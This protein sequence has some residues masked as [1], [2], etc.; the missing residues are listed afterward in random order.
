MRRLT[1]GKIT[2][3]IIIFSLL[4]VSLLDAKPM[5]LQ[6]DNTS[7]PV[8]IDFP[9]APQTSS[10]ATP[11]LVNSMTYYFSA[12]DK[13]ASIAYAVT[14]VSIPEK[15][16]SIPNDTAQIMIS[17]SLDTQIRIVDAA[18]GTKGKVIESGTA[19]ITGYPSKFL[20]VVRE[21]AP[22][23]FGYYRAVFVDRLLVTVWASG[24]DTPDNRSHA[25]AFAQSLRIKH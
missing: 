4:V 20:V 22:R 16:G 15:L 13:D 6:S 19:P 9:I 3:A 17:Q 12:H 14:I 2:V 23:L 24:L 8:V 10:M 7:F 11:T 21:T 1:N 18:V 25:V 5:R